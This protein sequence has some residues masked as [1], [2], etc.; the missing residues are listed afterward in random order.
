MLRA[1]AAYRPSLGYTQRMSSYASVLLLYMSEEDAFW[2]FAT[3]ME[4]CGLC[5]L[6]EDGFPLVHAYYDCWES[7][8]RHAK[9]KLH[10]HIHKELGG[11]M[12]L[13]DLNYEAARKEGDA[14]RYMIPSFYTT[15]WFQT[16][17]VGGDKP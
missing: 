4:H 11:F 17:L 7:L 1:Y 16:M 5:G 14:M 15:E 6:F 9:P 13:D 8:L 3:L 10:A 2:V 12:G